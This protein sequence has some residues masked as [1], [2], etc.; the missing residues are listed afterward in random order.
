MPF[1]ALRPAPSGRAAEA[2]DPSPNGSQRAR[3]TAG[4]LGSPAGAGHWAGVVWAVRDGAA[5]WTSAAPRVDYRRIGA[6]SRSHH[7]LLVGLA[8]GSAAGLACNAL[9]GGTP[10]LTHLIRYVTEPLG[11]LFL[12]ALLM[13]VMPIIFCAMAVGIGELQ[14][15]QLGRLGARTLAYTTLVSCLAVLIGMTLVNLLEPGVGASPELLEYARR[16]LAS[17]PRPPDVPTLDLLV[18]I[19]PSNPVAAAA[20]GDMLGVVCFSLL[21]GVGLAITKTDATRSLLRGIKG[22]FDVCMSLIG[23]V[24]RLAPL[25]VGALMFTMTARV[26]LAILVQLAAYVGV[27]LLGLGLHLFGVYSVLLA[28]IGKQSPWAFFRKIRLALATAF[29]TASSNATLPTALKVADAELGLPPHVSRFVL[30]AGATMNQNGTALFE[31]VTVLFL[32]Q[33][34]GVQLG[35]GAQALVMLVSVLAGIGSAGAPAGSL[36]V[37][38]MI[39]GL[40]GVP[41]EGVGLLLGVD[42]LLDMCRTTVNVGGDLVVAVLVAQRER[43]TVLEAS[44]GGDESTVS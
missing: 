7:R 27:V 6:E 11:T 17:T 40:V 22:L 24:L 34:Y 12:R 8:I 26:G 20:N 23:L 39:L 38:A 2:I 10:W 1:S 25:G 32:A 5:L 44:S 43:L 14:L 37:I 41:A 30:T 18:G 4:P 33:V 42:R 29:S 9:A 36:P 13:L 28:W 15:G 16:S 3:D 31:G 35:L 19:V 21:F